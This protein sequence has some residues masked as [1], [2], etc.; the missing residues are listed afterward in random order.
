MTSERVIPVDLDLANEASVEDLAQRVA[1][2]SVA[3]RVILNCSGLL[4]A[5]ALAPE[6][7]WRDLDVVQ[8][9]RLFQVN[10]LGVALLVKHLVP[11]LPRRQRSVF[12]TLSA[13]VGSIEDNHLG[14][15]YGYRASKAAS[16]MII[17][18]ASIEARRRHPDLVM[19]SLHPGTVDSDLSKPFSRRV[20]PEK[21]F[22]P[23]FSCTHLCEVIA[24]LNPGDSG[25][26]FA[27]DGQPI[28]W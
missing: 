11:L 10:T 27:W 22:S 7:S 20:R 3:P 26:F 9:V 23:E 2:A 14:G 24:S 6:R 5:E 4:H 1:S 17:K 8:L 28:P 15:W 13:R 19:A 18:T 21:L 12:V 16:N 25:G